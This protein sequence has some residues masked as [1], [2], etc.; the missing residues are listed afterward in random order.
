MRVNIDELQDNIDNT[1]DK[2]DFGDLDEIA[3]SLGNSDFNL[4]KNESFI[5]KI[6]KILS[7]QFA[8]QY[9]NIFGALFDLAGGVLLNIL[10]IV[11]E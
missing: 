5:S 9:D 10:P 11:S 2:I 6:G 8:D 4:F 3:T 1:L 7:G